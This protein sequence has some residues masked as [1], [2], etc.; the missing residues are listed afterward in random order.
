MGFKEMV[1]A[2]NKRTFLDTERFAAKRTIKYDGQVYQDIAVDLQ[3]LTEKDRRVSIIQDG[4][5]DN[6]QGLYMVSAV[7]Y[8]ALSD[9]GGKKPEKGQN[10]S[11]NNR[12]GGGGFFAKYQIDASTCE[13][14]MV[15]LSLEAIDE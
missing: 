14:G 13:F 3:Q 11:I 4:R 12:E 2:A 5:R 15:Q 1:E 6:T 8:C 10:I 7:L 9:I